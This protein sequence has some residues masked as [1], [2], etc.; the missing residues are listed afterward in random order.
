MEDASWTADRPLDSSIDPP[1]V[2]V[3]PHR[4]M[5]ARG[6]TPAPTLEARG[7]ILLL[8]LVLMEGQDGDGED[9][10]ALANVR[11]RIQRRNAIGRMA[12]SIC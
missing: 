2:F 6:S 11:P 8:G 12:K 9:E 1:V 3:A 4:A 7:G 10:K 5:R